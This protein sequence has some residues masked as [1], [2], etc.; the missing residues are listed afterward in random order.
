LAME[1]E[2]DPVRLHDG[3]LDGLLPATAHE[4]IPEN[5]IRA[6]LFRTLG[7]RPVGNAREF[8]PEN[9]I[10]APLTL[11]NSFVGRITSPPDIYRAA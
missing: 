8:I 4:F 10:C 6:P 1:G 11:T 3:A 2:R 9:S 5:S 7:G